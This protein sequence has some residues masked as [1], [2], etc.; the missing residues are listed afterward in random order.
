[1]IVEKTGV[2]HVDGEEDDQG[3]LDV[4][5]EYLRREPALI[6]AMKTGQMVNETKWPGGL[7]SENVW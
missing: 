4:T 3:F 2:D 6:R 7:Y 1:M 5:G